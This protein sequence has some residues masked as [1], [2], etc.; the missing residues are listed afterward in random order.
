MY[1]VRIDALDES[2]SR[3]VNE[4]SYKLLTFSTETVFENNITDILI[5]TPVTS[6]DVE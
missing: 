6:R 5:A 4:Y 1:M 2:K 3:S